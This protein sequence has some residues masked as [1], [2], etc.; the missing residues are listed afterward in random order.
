MN[1][2]KVKTMIK[3]EPDRKRSK[4]LGID[5]KTIKLFEKI[6][7]AVAPPPIM[8]VSQWA[9][10]ERRLSAESSAEAGRWNTDRAPYQREIL[11]AVNNPEC[12]EVVIMS[13][14]QVGK[15]ELIL[16]TIGYYID[17]DPAPIL[18]VNPTIEMAQ[19]F[20]KDRLAPMIRH[21]GTSRQGS[22]RKI[23]EFWKHNPSQTVS[24]RSY[25]YGRGEFAGFPG[26]KTY[27]NRLNGRDRPLSGQR[28][29][30]R[31]PD[32]VSR[33]ANDDLL[34]P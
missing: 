3:S 23:E 30:R 17:Y 5:L 29:N 22:R 25:H 24:G 16:N 10:A 4:D 12:E 33:K 14:A 27:P 28:R 15:T 32:Q 34:E 7:K 20:S 6:A 19:T 11:D 31:K 9:D 2:S 1:T 26:V 8:T 18:V 21:A 13:S